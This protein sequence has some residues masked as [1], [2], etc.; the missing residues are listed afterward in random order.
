MLLIRVRTCKSFHIQSPEGSTIS[1]ART[2]V[3][4]RSFATDA[5]N[6]QEKMRVF[7]T[8]KFPSKIFLSISAVFVTSFRSYRYESVQTILSLQQLFVTSASLSTP[9]CP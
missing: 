5:N 4:C 3:I 9:T 2:S 6:W 7:R 1:G 8:E